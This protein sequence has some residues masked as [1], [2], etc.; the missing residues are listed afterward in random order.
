MGEKK[1]VIKV[2]RPDSGVYICSVSRRQENKERAETGETGE[3]KESPHSS[4]ALSCPSSSVSGQ[5]GLA[6]SLSCVVSGHPPPVV[7]WVQSESGLSLP[8]TITAFTAGS[9]TSSLVWDSLETRHYGNY[10]CTATNIMGQVSR[11]TGLELSKSRG[12]TKLNGLVG[13]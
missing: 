6:A 7:H 10:S 11:Q 13:R 5:Q 12:F 8:A 3:K 9:L 2:D 4:P 1:A